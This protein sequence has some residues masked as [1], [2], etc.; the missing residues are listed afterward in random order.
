MLREGRTPCTQG[1]L[2]CVCVQAA[3]NAPSAA[4]AKN[5]VQLLEDGVLGLAVSNAWSPDASIVSPQP[6]LYTWEPQSLPNDTSPYYMRPLCAVR[7]PEVPRPKGQRNAP[8]TFSREDWPAAVVVSH[9]GPKGDDMF[10]ADASLPRCLGLRLGVKSS[11]LQQLKTSDPEDV[12]QRVWQ[13]RR[14]WD[15]VGQAKL[16]VVA[17][18]TAHRA[19]K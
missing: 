6:V 8:T 16:A 17:K 19:A 14:G 9:T 1:M 11:A 5:F 18:P 2:V 10:S 15:D 13:V 4:T 7:T 12:H 3:L